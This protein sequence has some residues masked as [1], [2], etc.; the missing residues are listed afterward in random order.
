MPS[1][2]QKKYSG[3][4]QSA[5]LYFQGSRAPRE[6]RA[7]A[8]SEHQAVRWGEGAPS[9]QGDAWK[10]EQEQ[11]EEQY[12][13]SKGHGNGHSDGDGNKDSCWEG[14]GLGRKRQ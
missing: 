8:G 6:Q 3:I 10:E 4:Q 12:S 11:E 2:K 9:K 13:H 5:K 1:S 7:P 14:Q